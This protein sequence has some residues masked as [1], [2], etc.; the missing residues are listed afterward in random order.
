LIYGGDLTRWTRFG[1]S[2]LLKF[3]LQISNKAV[4]TTKAVINDIVNNNNPFINAIDGSLDFNVPFSKTNPNAYYLQDVGGS[5]PNTQM[6]GNRFLALERS[7]NDS[8]R[9]SRFYTKPA[10]TF[11]GHD[12]GS[13]FLAPAQTIRS[14]YGTYV[15]GATKSGEAPI[16]LITAFR[17]YFIL[18]EAALRFGIAGDP[19]TYY[20]NGIKAAMKSV[21]LTDTEITAYFTANP[22]IVSLSGTTDQKLQQIITQKYV[23]SVG[24]AIESYNDYRRVGYPLLTPPIITEGDDPNTFPQRYPYTTQEGAS[25]PNQPNPRP[26]TNVKVWWQL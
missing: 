15:L 22:S 8:L 6:L 2:L 18:A 19:N 21:G 5:I 1:N 16:R 14:V 11:V 13:P 9:L 17:N 7:L 20:Q 10:A 23:A 25:N 24:N 4:D 26:K 12:N 3:A